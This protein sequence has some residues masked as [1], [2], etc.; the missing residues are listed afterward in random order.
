MSLVITLSLQDAIVMASDSRMSSQRQAVDMYQGIYESHHFYSDFHP[1]T[2]LIL[3]RIGVSVFGN[4]FL[5]GKTIFQHLEHIEEEFSG[6]PDVKVHEVARYL[7]KYFQQFQ[8]NIKSGFHVAGYDHEE[9]YYEPKVFRVLNIEPFLY[10]MNQGPR[11]NTIKLGVIWNGETEVINRLYFPS[12]QGQASKELI[13]RISWDVMSIQDGIDFCNHLIQTT[14]SYH[15][16]AGTQ[17]TVG[18]SINILVLKNQRAVWH[19]RQQYKL[20]NNQFS[21]L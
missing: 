4:A 3:N 19:T 17:H 7:G 10:Q 15:R 6:N 21:F 12:L 11:P 13:P 8:P 16:F 14:I 5:G 18:G 20:E 9:D 1:K 2:K